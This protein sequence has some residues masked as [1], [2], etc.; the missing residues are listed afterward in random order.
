MCKIICLIRTRDG[1]SLIRGFLIAQAFE[2]LQLRCKSELVRVAWY[3]NLV[4]LNE[5][6]TTAFAHAPRPQP[7]A[8]TASAATA[9]DVVSR[10]H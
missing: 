2:H 7:C 8:T 5:T 6:L 1:A 10:P 3:A 4:T 9:G